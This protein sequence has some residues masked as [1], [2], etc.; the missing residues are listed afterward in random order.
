MPDTED[1]NCSIINSCPPEIWSQ[2]FY[3]ACTDTGFTGRSISSTSRYFHEIAKKIRLRSVALFSIKQ[4]IAFVKLVEAL[5]LGERLVE[6]LY[7]TT[8]DSAARESIRS[9]SKEFYKPG[10]ETRGMP[11]SMVKISECSL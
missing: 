1:S 11:P 2:I 6:N 8:Y 4:I 10:F 9:L 3:S 7:I 5:P